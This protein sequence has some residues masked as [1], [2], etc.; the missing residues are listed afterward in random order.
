MLYPQDGDRIVAIDSVTSLHPVYNWLLSLASG[1]PDKKKTFARVKRWSFDRDRAVRCRGK[2]VRWICQVGVGDLPW[3]VASPHMFLNKIRLETDPA[4][5]VCLELWYRD[6]VRRQLRHLASENDT[7]DVSLY[8][9]Q[10][11]VRDHVSDF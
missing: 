10:P 8:A 7:F 3:V 6:R 2:W 9:S 1:D 4:A 5:F 11:F